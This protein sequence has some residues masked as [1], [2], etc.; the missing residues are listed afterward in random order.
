MK[1]A[2]EIAKYVVTKCVDDK[3]PISNL[4]L[5]KILYFIQI[6]YLKKGIEPFE[7]QFEAWQFGPVIP[8]IY[9]RYCGYGAMPI[10]I[11]YENINLQGEDQVI[12]DPIIEEKREL[13]PWDLVEDTHR[14]G[15]AWEIIFDNGN[16]YGNVIPLDLIKKVELTNGR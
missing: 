6:D 5:Q 16:G 15:G 3:K 10:T 9:Y 12:I 7:D 2:L 4:Q 13:Y 14:V 8:S 11:K 1:K